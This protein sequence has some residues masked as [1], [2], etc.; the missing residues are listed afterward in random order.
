MTALRS[1]SGQLRLVFAF[2]IGLLGY[3][4]VT[5]DTWAGGPRHHRL[6]TVPQE[7]RFMP[8]ALTI[9]AGE[10]VEWVNLDTD[11]H[12]VV[13]DDAFDT[14]GHKG[15]DQLLPGPLPRRT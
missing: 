14:A 6:V 15:T 5:S 1:R 7:D 12:T 4:G 3:F 13:S 8:F 9:R 10:T 2:V 11:D